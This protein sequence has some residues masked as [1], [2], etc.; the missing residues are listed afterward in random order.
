M[1]PVRLVLVVAVAENGVIGR[2]GGLPW[3][4]PSDLKTFRR[5]TIGKPVIMGRRT[6][7]SLKRPLDGRDNIVIT[8]DAS[9]A[10]EGVLRAASTSE[11]LELAG[12]CAARRKADEI[13]VIGGAEVFRA[14]FPLAD[15]IYL[16][17][18]HGRPAGDVFLPAFDKADWVEV[19]RAPMPRTER[20]EFAATLITLDRV[21]K[22]S[23]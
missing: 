13:A 20:D 7:G 5:L 10:G 17:E 3:R 4:L 6:F 22:S 15:R 12:A 21:H 14:F 8:G 16:T 19:A 18:V 1:S 2:G 23:P 11:A 9:I